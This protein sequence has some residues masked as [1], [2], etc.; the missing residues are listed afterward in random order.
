MTV[1]SDRIISGVKRRITTPSSQ[2][3][4]TDADILAIADDVTRAYL[5]PL[6]VSIRQDFFVTTT[7]TQLVDA[8]AAY[9]IP[10]RAVAR[11]LRDLKL[12]DASGTTRDVALVAIEDSHRYSQTTTIHSFYFKGDQ[13]VLVPEPNDPATGDYLQLWWENP[14]SA[15]VPISDAALITA[16]S[17]G[18]ITV[19]SI[20]S[21]MTSGVDVDF[22]KNVSG[23]ST[24]GMDIA[25]TGAGGTQVT[26]DAD[27]I[28]DTLA[29]G[30]WI[31]I[32]ETTP[33]LQLP[34]EAHPYL[35]TH[36]CRRMLF[37]LGDF[38]GAKML[39]D[40][41][42]KEEENLKRILE[43]R[44]QGEPTVIINRSGLLR[45]RRFMARRGLLF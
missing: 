7:E 28:P 12:I 23:S 39:D 6:F 26:V 27:D 41:L 18:T 21:D 1:T 16:I 42:R 20:P 30:D 33:V 4:M 24:I 11:G 15:L 29:V 36:V 37:A 35:E 44:I 45:G 14:P 38:D 5:V 32:A 19:S 17:G 10:A 43:P 31:A 9:D 40:D 34:N 3:L 22:V 8:Q 25:V 13:V 2:V